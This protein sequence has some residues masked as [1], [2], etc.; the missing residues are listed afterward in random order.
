MIPHERSLVEKFKDKPFALL[1]VDSDKDLEQYRTQ[2]K[3]EGV[4]WR[5]FHD[6]TTEGPIATRWN[7]HGWPTVYLIDHLGVIRHVDPEHAALDAALDELVA[8]AVK[9]AGQGKH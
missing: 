7:I 8:A 5:S 6:E 4:T 9:D 3:Q 2:A 1:G